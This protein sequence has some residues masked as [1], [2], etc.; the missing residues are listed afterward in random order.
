MKT[1]EE[2]FQKANK[3]KIELNQHKSKLRS[4]LMKNR[5][6]NEEKESWDWKLTLSSIAFSSILLVFTLNLAGGG[7]ANSGNTATAPSNETFYAKLANN[8]NVSPITTEGSGTN[9]LQMVEDDTRTVFYFNDRNVLV[10]SEVY[11]N[12]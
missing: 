5:Y 1:V 7:S 3:D 6:F 2:L 8:K 12:K 11:N 4:V 9:A 10:Q